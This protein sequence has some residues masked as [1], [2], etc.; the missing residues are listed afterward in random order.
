MPLPFKKQEYALRLASVQAAMR[1]SGLDALLVADPSNIYWLTGAEDWCFYTPQF[2]LVVAD[3]PYSSEPYWLGR[4]MDAAGAR[5]SCWMQ[6]PRILSY[7]EQYVQQAGSHPGEH[8][9]ATLA[10]LGLAQARI[11]CE[12]D[13]YFFSPRSLRS[14][15]QVLPAAEFVDDRLMVNWLRAI[16]SPDEVAYMRQAAAIAGTAMQT[17]YDTIAPGVRQCDVM[18]EVLRSQIAP[19][20]EFG[21]DMTGLSPILLA[22]EKASTAHPAW[23]DEPFHDGQTV[24][25]ELGGCRRRYNCGLARTLHLGG[26]APALLLDTAAAVREGL[27]AVLDAA[28]PGTTAAALHAAWQQVLARYGLTKDSRIGYSIGAGF[29]PDWG[30]HTISLRQD[31][32]TLLQAGMTFHVILG[33]WQQ[34]W[35][36]ELSETIL[37]TGQ[38]AECLTQFPRDIYV[39]H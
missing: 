28:R 37:I 6:A 36:M 33:M 19:G 10:D 2:A 14:M 4:A 30:E 15:Q 24:A 12:F 32:E 39:K 21:G 7:P 13:S 17:A 20:P 26:S 9:G 29:S 35:G 27:D 31:D 11:G 25:L 16:K 1:R 3:G 23:T 38:A 8:I 5:H 18:A 22:G 34:G